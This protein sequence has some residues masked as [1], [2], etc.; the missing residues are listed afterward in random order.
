MRTGDSLKRRK[1]LTGQK[2]NR[3]G[4]F[5]TAFIASVHRDL[6]ILKNNLPSPLANP[7]I[8][9]NTVL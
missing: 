7:E 3:E 5:K 9:F 2:F 6:C 1:D 8:I 4:G